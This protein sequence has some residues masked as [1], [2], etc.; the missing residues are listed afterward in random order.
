MRNFLE[1]FFKG[2]TSQPQKIPLL[3]Q[4]KYVLIKGDLKNLV[5]KGEVLIQSFTVV[6][7]GGMEWCQYQ[8]KLE[9]G[10]GTCISPN[11]VIYAAGPGGITIGKNFDCGPGVKVFASR[12]DYEKGPNHHIFEPVIIEDNVIAYANV[13]ISPGVK[14]GEGAVLAAGSVIVQD[15]E[16][17][18]LAGGV[19]AKFIRKLKR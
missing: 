9:I 11:C 15:V 3:R 7:L 12:T 16:P 10:G 1:Y 19:P 4:E 5:L 6:H 14:I 17:Y 8:G 13:I 2:R 18:T